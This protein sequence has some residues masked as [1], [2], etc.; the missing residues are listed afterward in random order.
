MKWWW[1]GWGGTRERA[2]MV[3]RLHLLPP[4]ASLHGAGAAAAATSPHQPVP[5]PCP[6]PQVKAAE[7]VLSVVMAQVILGE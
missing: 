3:L 6:L 2:L 7:P 1:V 5:P 4:H